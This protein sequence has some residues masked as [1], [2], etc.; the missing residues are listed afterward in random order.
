M[1]LAQAVH[2]GW[3]TGVP[4]ICRPDAVPVCIACQLQSR[5]ISKYEDS[6]SW[7]QAVRC[8]CSTSLDENAGC[9]DLETSVL[10]EELQSEAHC[11]SCAST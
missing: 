11:T 3:F 8:T 2:D 6:Q 10:H 1:W 4:Q 9:L 5:Q 7:T